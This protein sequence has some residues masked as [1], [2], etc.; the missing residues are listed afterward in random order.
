MTRLRNVVLGLVAIV[1]VVQPAAASTIVPGALAGVE[2]NANN[3]FP[4]NIADFSQTSLRYQQVYAASGFLG[5]ML[6]GGISFRPDANGGGAFAS[7]ISNVRI[8]LS[9]TGA[10]PDALNA[11]FA[12]NVGANNTTVFNGSLSLS[13]AFTGP[14]GGPKAFDINIL[15]TTPF[16]YNPALGNLLL[17]VRMFVASDTTQFDA[18]DVNGDAISRMFATDVNA[19]T[20]ST[21]SLGL[22]TRFD[23]AAAAA[24]PEPATLM[25]VGTGFAA[26]VRA[27]RRRSR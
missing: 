7:T 22:V 23:D 24:V 2:G 19:T 6:I 11:V 26:A 8:D 18:Q 21:D 4:F 9:T 5:S 1:G 16:F 25:L 15:L 14:A 13:S 3:G 27:R 12:A 20:G 10:A 17:D